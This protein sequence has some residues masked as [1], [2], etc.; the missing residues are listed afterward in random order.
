MKETVDQREDRT[1][2]LHSR[3]VTEEDLTEDD[4]RSIRGLLVAA[5]P[6][7]A[8]VFASVSYLGARPEYRLWLES[9]DGEMLAHL[10]FERRVIDAGG[11]EVR[12]AGVG[13]VSV[14]PG[15]QGR[16]V[17]RLLMAELE[18]VLRTEAP[19]AFGLLFCLEPLVG[20]YAR[21]GWYRVDQPLRVI[22]P[23]TGEATEPTWPTMILPALESLERWPHEGP[24][25]LR[26]MPW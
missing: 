15:A 10:D 8:E 26:G 16:G 17:G 4:H 6:R 11:V 5:F 24:V 13:E 9:H 7:T 22:D 18:R 2:A 3:L 19:A 23:K 20:F 12:V 21:A 25:D 14:W 1:E